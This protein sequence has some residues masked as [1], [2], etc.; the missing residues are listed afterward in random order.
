M[1][2]DFIFM[3]TKD[4]QTVSDAR[5]YVKEIAAA[6]AKHIGFKDIGLPTSELKLLA[7]DLKKE[8][9]KVYLEVVS[10]DAESEERS[11][12]VAMDLNVDYLLGGTRPE[13]IAAI[14]KDHSL[15]YYPFVGTIEDHPSILTGTIPEI[16]AHAA[17]I[18]A[19]DGVDGLDLLAYRFT[20]E[21]IP[22]LIQEVCE[23]SSK[24][25]VV[26][27]SIDSQKRIE[28]VKTNGASGFTVGTAA[29]DMEF[30]S[31]QAGISGQVYSILEMSRL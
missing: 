31:S 21:D 26:A 18:T 3:L 16:A 28:V 24:P 6:G 8:G 29:F 25:V 23:A 19:I 2:I 10:L 30:P 9:V 5:E 20:G 13:L 22:Q 27:G 11:A 15:K 17:Q 7:E 14:V 12:R 1:S 4:D